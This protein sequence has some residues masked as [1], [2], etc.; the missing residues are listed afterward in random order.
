MIGIICHK[1]FAMLL[2]VAFMSM[3]LY[4]QNQTKKKKV[5]VRVY[6]FEGKKIEKGHFHYATDSILELRTNDRLM[7]IAIEDIS[8]I[9][10]KR[11]TG[12]SVLVGSVTGVVLGSIIGAATASG[13]ETKETDAWF[14]GG[15]YTTGTSP[16]TG[17]AIGGGIGIAG[18]ALAGLGFSVFK[19]SKTY[20]IEGDIEKWKI[21]KENFK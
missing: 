9:K 4:S 3:S 13:E 7:S 8:Y 5:F 20:L 11:S 19:K 17:A 6:N 18:G 16:G 1:K 2:I 15:E 21:F 12:N 14:S 10:T